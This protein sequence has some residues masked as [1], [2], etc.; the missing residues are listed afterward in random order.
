MQKSSRHH[1][2]KICAAALRLA[3]AR[4]WENVTLEQIAKAAKIPLPP[5]K[6]LF[7]DSNAILP[8]IVRHISAE[9]FK[10]CDKP[11]HNAPPHD[12]LFDVMMARFDRLQQSRKAVLSIAAFARREPRSAVILFQAQIEAM[13]STL[14]FTGFASGKA[15]ATLAPLA[16][17]GIHFAAFRAW[18]HDETLD[19]SKTMAA[20]DWYLRYA[21]R[22]ATLLRAD[23]V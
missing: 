10:A 11:D 8:L 22:A 18:Q 16:V 2:Q 17:W 7:A 20:L 12:R 5:L 14:A 23:Y 19:M 9:T 15:C 4:G 13:R 21:G 3:A 1:D 6:A